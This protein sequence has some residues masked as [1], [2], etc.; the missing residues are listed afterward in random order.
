MYRQSSVCA[1]IRRPSP[2][3]KSASECVADALN[4]VGSPR[5][6]SDNIDAARLRVR[7]TLNALPAVTALAAT[8]TNKNDVLLI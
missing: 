4:R 2:R 7:A 3:E 1:E 8:I 5:D 6:T